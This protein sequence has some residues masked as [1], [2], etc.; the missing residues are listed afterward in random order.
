MHD[1]AAANR[2]A[3]GKLKVYVLIRVFNLGADDMNMRFYVD[4][5]QL[6]RDG[7]LVFARDKYSVVPTC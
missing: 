1:M 4:P 3:G 2:Q 5:W 6:E 7:K